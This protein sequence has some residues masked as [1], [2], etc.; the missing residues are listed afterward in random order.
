MSEL[1]PAR[2]AETVGT[3]VTRF[4]A[5][6]HGVLSK[7]TVLPWEDADEYRALVAALVD[8]HAPR[9][10]TEEHLVEELAGVFWRKRRLRLAE[11]A[12]HRRGL[13]GTTSSSTVYEQHVALSRCVF[14]GLFRELVRLHAGG[15][16][17]V[18]H[19]GAVGPTTY[20]RAAACGL[21]RPAEAGRVCATSSTGTRHPVAAAAGVLRQVAAQAE[22]AGGLVEGRDVGRQAGPD[23]A[24]LMD[25]G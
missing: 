7:F 19:Y 15:E 17:R 6:R 22:A 2:P 16:T 11:A 10:P 12:A 23:G 9:G 8:E 13:H 1:K 5:L 3:E 20:W 18:F 21:Q 25:E 24:A 14:V 4:N